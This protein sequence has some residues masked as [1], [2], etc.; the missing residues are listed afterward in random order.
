ME[1]LPRQWEQPSPSLDP[2]IL[3]WEGCNGRTGVWCLVG[4][5][6]WQPRSSGVW[7]SQCQQPRCPCARGEGGA[8]VG[9]GASDLRQSGAH[10]VFSEEGGIGQRPARL[11]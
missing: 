6:R 10:V 2:G 8:R 7:G 11:G 4:P 9:T 3:D 1:V 5:H